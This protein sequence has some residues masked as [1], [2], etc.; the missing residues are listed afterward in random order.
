MTIANPRAGCPATGC[1]KKRRPENFHARISAGPKDIHENCGQRVAAFFKLGPFYPLGT[2]LSAG[3]AHGHRP[4][5]P[6]LGARMARR[7]SRMAAGALFEARPSRPLGAPTSNFLLGLGSRPRFHGPFATNLF[8]STG[9]GISGCCLAKASS[10]L[11]AACCACPHAVAATIRSGAS[12][13]KG[14]A[15]NLQG[16]CG[17]RS[18]A[19]VAAGSRRRSASGTGARSQ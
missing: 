17:G 7:D 6:R 4:A 9:C 14:M 2:G 11:V 10:R 13:R 1:L 16:W 18:R 19:K 5:P 8:T 3:G 15:P 12:I